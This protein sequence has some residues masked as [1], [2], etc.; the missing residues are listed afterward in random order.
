MEE[1]GEE[2]LE[3]VPMEEEEEEVIVPY[4]SFNSE[5]ARIII[6]Y[7][8]KNLTSAMLKA[9]ELE[10]IGILVQRAS[11]NPVNLLLCLECNLPV[12]D[13]A[14]GMVRFSCCRRLAGCQREGL[15]HYE[16]N[17]FVQKY[18]CRCQDITNER[19][20]RI[21]LLVCD[22]CE[23]RCAIKGCNSGKMCLKCINYCIACKGSR[24]EEHLVGKLC[25]ICAK[26]EIEAYMKKF[27]Q[28]IK[29]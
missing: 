5:M 29:K 26:Q 17:H 8:R 2:S 13:G 16:P 9:N 28:S 20:G 7:L 12:G 22:L 23:R 3:P 1:Q 18:G 4:V 6:L 25:V 21:S 14:R 24:C 15:C 10:K 11:P 19:G 27:P